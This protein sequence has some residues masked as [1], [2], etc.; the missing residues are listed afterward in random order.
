ME[1]GK[2]DL[3]QEQIESSEIFLMQAL[4]ILQDSKHPERYL[5]LESLA[6]LY[7]KKSMQAK[8][9]SNNEQVQSLQKK[10]VDFL[11]QAMEV[12]QSYFP[13]DCPHV[14]RIKSKLAKFST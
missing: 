4:K 8:T 12:V 6:D 7:S 5:C 14:V 10:A 11:N 2:I 9:N 3:L 1:L 13:E